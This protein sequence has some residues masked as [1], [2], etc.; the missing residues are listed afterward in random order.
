MKMMCKRVCLILVVFAADCVG[1]GHERGEVTDPR[2]LATKGRWVTYEGNPVLDL[3]ADGQWDCGTLATMSVLKVG[4]TY[5][6]YYEAGVKGV[7]DYQNGHA[8]STDGIHWVKDKANPVIPFGNK[9]KWDDSETWDPFVL[10]EDGVFKMWYGGTALRDGKRD[11]QVGYATSRDGTHFTGRK[12]ISNFSRGK[13]GDM[14]VVHDTQSGKYYM[15]YRDGNYKAPRLFRAESANETDFDFDNAVRIEVAGEKNGYRCPHVFIEGDLWYMY[16]GFKYEPQAGYATS[17]DGL[18]WK[19]KNT[20][21]IKG[22]DAEVLKVAGDL[23]LMFYCPTEYNLGHKL[24]CDIRVAVFEGNLNELASTEP[25]APAH[26]ENPR[27]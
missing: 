18:H 6:M 27:H 14:H 16:Y 12:Q 8:V 25:H 7:R 5:H 24:G 26:A 10:Y 11:F 19:A 15:Y 3:G 4:D 2:T 1:M 17:S 23:Y 22:D 21:V 9:G 20:N 13:V